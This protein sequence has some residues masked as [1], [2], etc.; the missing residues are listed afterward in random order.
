MSF[1]EFLRLNWSE[2]L[3]L[4]MQH[5]MLVFIAIIAAVLI[6]VPVGIALTRYRALRG[7]VLGVAK[8]GDEDRR[9]DPLALGRQPPQSG[10]TS[11]VPTSASGCVAANSTARY[12]GIR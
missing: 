3:Q 12:F 1:W 6:G 2:L 10:R 8:D 5:I 9:G 7:P 4:V 11:I